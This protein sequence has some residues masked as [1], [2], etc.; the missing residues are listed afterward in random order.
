[1]AFSCCFTCCPLIAEPSRE[2][3]RLNPQHSRN[4]ERIKNVNF[5]KGT[6]LTMK[7]VN[8]PEFDALF[9]SIAETFNKQQDHCLSL[10]E[11]TQTLRNSYDCS[12]VSSLSVCMEKILQEHSAYNVQVCMEGYKFWLDVGVEEVP[13]KLKQTQQQV[14]KLNFATKG[15]VSTTIEEMIYSVHQCQDSLMEKVKDSSPEYLDWMRLESNLKE[16]IEKINQA[17]KCSEEYREEANYVLLNM[18]K[19]ANL[20]L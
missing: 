16:N 5:T 6:P 10:Q 15:I 11:A 12:P 1:M 19:S 4:R 17:Q 7:R 20:T 18:A 3:E 9:N 14:R 2:R 8:V 13:Q